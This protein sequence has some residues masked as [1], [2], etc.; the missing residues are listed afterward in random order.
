MQWHALYSA[1]LLLLSI[2]HFV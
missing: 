2:Q 1:T